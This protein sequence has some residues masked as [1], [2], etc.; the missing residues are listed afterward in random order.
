MRNDEGFR[1]PAV[2]RGEIVAQG[3]RDRDGRR[4]VVA[5]G[6]PLGR[7]HER[8]K[9]TFAP[10]HVAALD[11]PP[12]FVPARV[13]DVR[14]HDVRAEDRQP[15]RMHHIEV[16][17]DHHRCRNHEAEDRRQRREP[18]RRDVVRHDAVGQRVEP[19][20]EHVDFVRSREPFRE[21]RDVA[22]VAQ[23][24]VVVVDDERDPQTFV[25]VQQR[26]PQVSARSAPTT[27]DR[28]KRSS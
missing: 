19:V 20:G 12:P 8:G 1:P 21:L 10:R 3:G 16:A 27:R 15:L 13:R 2:R 9:D 25:A 5:Q 26:A 22:A 6:A 28:L 4:P 11:E 7:N 18:K 24:A 23:H 14:G 17:A